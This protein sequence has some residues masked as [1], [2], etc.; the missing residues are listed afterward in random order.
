[1]ID[2]RYYELIEG[3][4]YPTKE[5]AY[6]VICT[7]YSNIIGV[8]TYYDEGKWYIVKKKKILM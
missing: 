7:L 6:E 4:G 2:S 1:M 5:E 3:I 8:T